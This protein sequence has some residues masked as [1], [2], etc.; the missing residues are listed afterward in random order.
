MK[1]KL[2]KKARRARK[3]YKSRFSLLNQGVALRHAGL[4]QL[5]EQLICKKWRLFV[6]PL[7]LKGSRVWVALEGSILGFGKGVEA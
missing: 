6:F 4:A 2:I 3:P 7:E 1:R 5:V